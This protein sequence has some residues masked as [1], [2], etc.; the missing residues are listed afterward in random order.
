VIALLITQ[1]GPAVAPL[2]IVGVAVSYIVVAVLDHRRSTRR[3]AA[4]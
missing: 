2:V 1:G 4:A 3:P